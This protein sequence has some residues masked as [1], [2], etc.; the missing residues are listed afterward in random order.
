MLLQFLT[1]FFFIRP[2]MSI[3]NLFEPTL[4]PDCIANA[5]GMCTCKLSLLSLHSMPK[6]C[7]NSCGRYENSNMKFQ[8]QAEHNL[9]GPANVSTWAHA[10]HR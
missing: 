2:F 5:L 8:T 9:R 7:I 10:A 1:E 3:R 4:Q 6:I